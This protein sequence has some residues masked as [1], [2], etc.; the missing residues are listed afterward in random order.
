[1]DF[2]IH[3]TL[4]FIHDINQMSFFTQT[5]QTK[6]STVSRHLYYSILSKLTIHLYLTKQVFSSP[7]LWRLFIMNPW[8]IYPNLTCIHS[9][10]KKPQNIKTRLKHT[11]W[12]TLWHT[13]LLF[14]KLQ[15]SDKLLKFTYDTLIRKQE[16]P[17]KERKRKG[18]P[19]DFTQK[20]HN[21]VAAVECLC[22][23]H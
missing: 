3:P 8:K 5:H 7:Q 23:M 9:S 1:M 4:V 19:T 11:Q 21:T 6:C 17:G 13:K 20:H 22:C 18:K 2:Q 14:D 15:F 12:Q 10:K 16:T